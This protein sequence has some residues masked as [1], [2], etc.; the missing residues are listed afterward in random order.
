M[1]AQRTTEAAVRFW[2]QSLTEM[3]YTQW[4]TDQKVRLGLFWNAKETL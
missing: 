4:V 3:S 1:S 2:Q